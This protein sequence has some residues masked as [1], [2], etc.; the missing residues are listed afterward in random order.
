M[1]SSL[2]FIISVA[3]VAFANTNAGEFVQSWKACAA[4]GDAFRQESA[5]ADGPGAPGVRKYAPDRLIDVKHLKLEVT[6]DFDKRTIEGTATITFSPIATPLDEVRLDAI[7]LAISEVQSSHAV[8]DHYVDYA[9]LVVLFKEPIPAG[10]EVSVTVFYSA[11]PQDGLFFRTPAMGYKEGDSHLWSQGEPQKH[12]HW[13]P[14]YDYPNERFTTEVICTVPEGMI[15]LSNGRLIETKEVEGGGKMFHWL[16]DQPHVNYLISLVAGHFKHLEDDHGEIPLAFYT[17]PSEF[18]QAAGS[19]IDTKAILEFFEQETGVPYPWD[20]YFSVC[21]QGY[22]FGG[23]E[24]TSMTTLTTRTLFSPE[25]ENIH[26]SRHLDAHEAAHQW[27]GDLVTCKDWTHLWLNEGFATYYTELYEEHKLGRDFLLYNMYS[28]AKGILDNKDEKPI[29]WRGYK[30]PFEQFDYR[31]Y[32]KGAWVLHMLRSQLGSELYRKCVKTYLDR[33]RGGVVVTED[34]NAVIEEVTGRSFDGFFDQWVHHGGEPTLQ[35]DYGWDGKKKRAKLTVSQIQK[36]SERVLL[37]DFSLPI[38]FYTKEGSYDFVVDIR[39]PREDF[40]FELPDAPTAVRVDPDYTV[41][42][43]IRLKV[44]GPLQDAQVAMEGDVIGQILGIKMIS[45]RKDQKTLDLL[46]DRLKKDPF[47]GVRVEA[48][49]AIADRQSPEALQALID[50]LNQEDA[51]VRREVVKGIGRFYRP[52]ARQQLLMVV[53]KEK[54]PEIVAIALEGLG[55]FPEDAIDEALIAALDRDS[56]RHRIARAALAGIG[57]Q[58]DPAF[59]DPV[60]AHL[61]EKSDE[62]ED[63]D[64][65]NALKVL[66]GL[67]RSSEPEKRDEVREFI[68]GFLTDPRNQLT[69]PTIEGLGALGDPRAIATLEAFQAEGGPKQRE[70]ET[71]RKMIEQLKGQGRPSKQLTDLR[72]EV[73]DL[74]QEIE[75]LRGMIEEMRKEPVAPEN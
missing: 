60:L 25:T 50:G 27:F 67:A 63:R 26:T 69:A 19:F 43:D 23:M 75:Q 40:L 72:G 3:L 14:S 7:D 74:Q 28:K 39:Q 55:K 35:V 4:K 73:L 58:D 34:L 53:E 56:Y 6:P 31:A 24:N 20:K 5:A 33:H 47:Y 66:G 71:A 17:P 13:F 21:V 57:K 70:A 37:F 10:E 68:G 65:G 1:R 42:A 12:R 44:P 36:L 9:N 51:L 62:F 38:R 49:R 32:P 41:L 2:Y 61:R 48:A 16:Q 18:E 15:V 46:T 8:E 54:N 29:A 22:H 45:G 30:M 64:L 52:M 59:V 11:E